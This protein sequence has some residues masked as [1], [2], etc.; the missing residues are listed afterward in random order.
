MNREHMDLEH[1]FLKRMA[2]E[3]RVREKMDENGSLWIK[4]YFGGGPHFQNWLSQVIE[5]KGKDN[6]EVEKADSTG[7]Q[8]YEESGEKMYRIWVK[9]SSMNNN[10]KVS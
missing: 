3:E 9:D 6:V 7:F 10:L 4:V 2:E 1:V 5:L 8:C